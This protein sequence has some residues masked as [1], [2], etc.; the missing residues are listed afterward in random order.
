[1]PRNDMKTI[2]LH[3]MFVN[4]AKALLEREIAKAPENIR[5]LKVIHG[6]N[7]G[8]ALRDMVRKRM[9]SPR[10]EAIVPTFS[11]DGETIIY[12]K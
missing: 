3:G 11:N 8:T 2:D 1:M 9:R 10:I 6:S 5:R 4:D 7:N 12:L